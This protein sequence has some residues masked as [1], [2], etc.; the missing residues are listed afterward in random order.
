MYNSSPFYLFLT[1]YAGIGRI[2]QAILDSSIPL[3]AINLQWGPFFAQ[4][5]S[6]A[7]RGPE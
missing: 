6:Q 2:L 4:P 7:A 3:A 1:K 5:R